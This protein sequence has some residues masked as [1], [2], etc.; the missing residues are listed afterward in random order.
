MLNLWSESSSEFSAAF[1]RGLI[2]A[3]AS[4]RVSAR[5]K[6]CEGPLPRK[7]QGRPFFRHM[8][9]NANI[10]AAFRDRAWKVPTDTCFRSFARLATIFVT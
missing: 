3:G 2:E 8:P 6:V 9:L 7:S 4:Q 10:H 1:R 5:G